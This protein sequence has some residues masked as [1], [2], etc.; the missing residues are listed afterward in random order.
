MARTKCPASGERTHGVTY[1]SHEGGETK[2][3]RE[4]TCRDCGRSVKLTLD[5]R[6]RTH[7]FKRGTPGG[8]E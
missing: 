5:D 6:F 2:E 8:D 7:Y 4:S 3:W 1:V